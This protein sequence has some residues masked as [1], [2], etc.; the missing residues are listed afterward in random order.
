MKWPNH[1]LALDELRF[2]TDYMLEQI[3]MF[4]KKK[5]LRITSYPYRREF[6][7][8]EPEDRT[9]RVFV[10]VTYS[11]MLLL[12]G[13]SVIERASICFTTFVSWMHLFAAPLGGEDE[14]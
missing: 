3:T 12:E 14:I 13:G 11:G 2:P 7:F 1:K 5:G 6:T 10:E 4:A 9:R 8:E